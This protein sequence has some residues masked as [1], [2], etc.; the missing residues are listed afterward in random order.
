MLTPGSCVW[1]DMFITECLGCGLLEKCYVGIAGKEG[2]GHAHVTNIH[3]KLRGKNQIGGTY[4]YMYCT[5]RVYLFF[6]FLK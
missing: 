4:T 6:F 3:E 5:C 2:V 1:G